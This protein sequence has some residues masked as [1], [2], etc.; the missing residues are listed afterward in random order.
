MAKGIFCLETEWEFTSQKLKDETTIQPMLD[1]MKNS[2]KME[3]V[4]RR[5]ATRADL[6]FYLK[7]LKKVTFNKYEIVYL[8]F[9]GQTQSIFLEGE[10]KKDA[11]ISLTELA[12]IANGAFK[13][14]FVHFGTCRTLLGSESTL[15]E[16]KTLTGAKFISGY[17]RSVDY[18]HSSLM[19][20]AYFNELNKISV[21][22][23]TVR[24]LLD[25]RYGGLKEELGFKL[26]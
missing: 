9:H 5:V 11:F 21:K 18:T 25:K 8:S 6:F 14:K 3:Y 4:Y 2:N 15:E 7:Q 12:E 10:N 1:F 16:F 22:Y 24:S 13:D 17:T 20:I 19:D 23:N 26:I